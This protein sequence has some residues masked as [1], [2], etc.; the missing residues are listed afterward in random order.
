MPS[1]EASAPESEPA[2]PGSQAVAAAAPGGTTGLGLAPSGVAW[3]TFINQTS[4]LMD[5]GYNDGN[6]FARLREAKRAAVA[7]GLLT[8]DRSLAGEA[9]ARV[10]VVAPVAVPEPVAPAGEEKRGPRF[11]KMTEAERI[12]LMAM[13]IRLIEDDGAAVDVAKWLEAA[14][15]GGLNDPLALRVLGEAYLKLGRTEQAAAQFRQAMFA[16]QR[17][18]GER[19]E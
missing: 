16:R 14:V 17:A 8:V 6:L 10:A 2:V 7:A 9:N 13:R 5:R 18:R 11:T 15:A 19:S 12:D 3:P 4:D 1:S